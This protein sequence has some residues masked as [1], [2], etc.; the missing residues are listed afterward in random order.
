[1]GQPTQGSLLSSIPCLAIQVSLT[2]QRFE[3]HLAS[4]T[5]FSL[6]ISGIGKDLNPFKK[7]SQNFKEIKMLKTAIK[8]H[9]EEARR[10]KGEFKIIDKIKI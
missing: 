5:D 2:P 10:V 4:G 7:I 1:L 6:V 9:Q 3:I 8:S